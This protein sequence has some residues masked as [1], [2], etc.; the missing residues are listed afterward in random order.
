[1]KLLTYLVFFISDFYGGEG[2][3]PFMPRALALSAA[4]TTKK[5][6]GVFG[7]CGLVL[8]YWSFFLCQGDFGLIVWYS[9]CNEDD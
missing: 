5:T 8:F 2:N 7:L 4:I 1:M 9:Q 3:V 6:N